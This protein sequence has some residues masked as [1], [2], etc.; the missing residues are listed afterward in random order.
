M[1]AS[2]FVIQGRDQGTRFELDSQSVA[3]PLGR[4]TGNRIQLHDTEV[5]RRHAEL[6]RNGETFSIVDLGSSNGTFVNNQRIQQQELA[7]GDQVQIGR[8]VML[9]TGLGEAPSSSLGA[10][11]NI[12]IGS[13]D[14][15]SRI[16]HSV[17]REEGSRIF[18]P[19]FATADSSQGQ[20][21]ARARSNLQ[22]MY[23]TALAVSHTLDI[24][25][26][27]RRIMDLIF[28]WV[29]ADRGCIMLLDPETKQLRPKV[30]R[31]RKGLRTDAAS[32]SEERITISSTILDYV[33][34]RSEGV[35]TSDARQDDRFDTAASIVHS[36]VREAICVPMQGRYD[37]VGLI[38]IDTSTP[39]S[40]ALDRLTGI[41]N[42]NKFTEEHLKLMVAIG[43]QAA[44]AVEDTNYY[45]AMVQSERLAAIGQT[46][47]SL[48]HH[49]K[50]ILQGIRGGS[51][52]IEMGLAE[53]DEEVVSKGWYIVER[54]QRKISA[55]VMDM[56][57]FSK[58]RE[59]EFAAADL[60]SVVGDVIEL[61]Q[62][63]ADE[64]KV[65]L[66]W[67]PDPAIPRLTFDSEGIQRAVLNI[68][69][70]ALDACDQ[71]EDGLVT[72]RTEQL[73]AAGNVQVSVEDNGTG[74]DADSLKQLFSPF[75]SSK[76]SRGTGLGLAVSQKILK[77]HGGR[78]H[79][80]S[81]PGEGSRF[82][83]EFPAMPAEDAASHHSPGDTS[84]TGATTSDGRVL[85]EPA[86]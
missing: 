59:P 23:R 53:H 77:E 22:I 39:A 36:G 66:R 40:R 78:I 74:I 63:R 47:A 58:E 67:E 60:N 33:M 46:I 32:Q 69:T 29:E 49:V 1:A 68:V 6:R 65:Q 18:S 45:S 48:S 85:S 3:F 52:L 56:L 14:D 35:L 83:L 61:M 30:R 27:L 4:D 8:T 17:S 72:L 75:F 86:G 76:G 70:N 84:A 13:G 38:Y 81:R 41:F 16:L 42:A 28:E 62:S 73:P 51:Y 34:Q 21:L 5:S 50:N 57:T 9:F 25:Q 71:R 7:S 37:V 44:L 11:V 31:D 10:Q 55:L 54:N 79:V 26:L 12:G 20:W 80:E 82:T 43:H 2:L 19:D 15:R 24:D 64:L